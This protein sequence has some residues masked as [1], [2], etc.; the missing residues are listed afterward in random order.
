[1]CFLITSQTSTVSPDTAVHNT[2]PI[3]L[4][5]TLYDDNEYLRSEPVNTEFLSEIVSV[6][7]CTNNIN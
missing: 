5:S 1:M 7:L 4:N 3:Y 2:R 6:N